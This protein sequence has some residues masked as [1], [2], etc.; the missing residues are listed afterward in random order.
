MKKPSLN[1]TNKTIIQNSWDN[2]SI[3]LLLS[4]AF[5]PCLF[6]LNGFYNG[7]D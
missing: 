4:I 7:P 6:N 2:E 1:F 3:H 5:K